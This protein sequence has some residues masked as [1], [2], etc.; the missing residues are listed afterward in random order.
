[1]STFGFLP[2]KANLLKLK[3]ELDVIKDGYNL[4]DHKREVLIRELLR[5]GF[6]IKDLKDNLEE[7]LRN[8]YDKFSRSKKKMGQ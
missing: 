8:T 7:T 2:T 1:M 6:E 3:Q 4:L 5:M